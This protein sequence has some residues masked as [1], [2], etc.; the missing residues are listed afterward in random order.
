MQLHSTSVAQL[1]EHWLRKLCF[2]FGCCLGICCFVFLMCLISC[3]SRYV[4]MIHKPLPSS[5]SRHGVIHLPLRQGLVD[6][7]HPCILTLA[8]SLSLSLSFSLFFST[9]EPFIN[10]YYYIHCILFAI[11]LESEPDVNK[12][13][14]SI[15]RMQASTRTYDL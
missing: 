14:V 13:L 15:P 7:G 10:M 9:N 11:M 8:L 6:T 12:F 4:N 3:I 2:W 5:P 1:V